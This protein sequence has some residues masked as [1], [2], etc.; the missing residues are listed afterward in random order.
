[1]PEND[2]SKE[3]LG[4]EDFPA[5]E[6]GKNLRAEFSSLYGK[7]FLLSVLGIGMTLGLVVFPPIA[8]YAV[9]ERATLLCMALLVLLLANRI[10]RRLVV[11][12]DSVIIVTWRKENR[13][14]LEEIAS[15]TVLFTGRMIA[16]AL[17]RLRRSPPQGAG[18]MLMLW[19]NPDS[20]KQHTQVYSV[21][22]F[23]QEKGTTVRWNPIFP[24]R[25]FPL[26]KENCSS[27][28]LPAKSFWSWKM[29]LH[30]S[31]FTAIFVFFCSFLGFHVVAKDWNPG[32]IITT[33]IIGSILAGILTWRFQRCA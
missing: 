7:I 2:R 5:E 6:V 9:V 14:P 4:M 27:A 22:R 32:L 8:Q 15:F 28:K 31:I 12:G 1:L 21:L 25:F 26:W 18:K 11:E 10:I 19:W 29:R 17:I 16:G 30:N 13:I 3:K 23:L 24:M 33:S 20:V